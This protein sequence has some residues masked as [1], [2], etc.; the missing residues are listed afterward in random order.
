MRAEHTG[1]SRINK[2][3]TQLETGECLI[4]KYFDVFASFNDNFV[5]ALYATFLEN[6]KIINLPIKII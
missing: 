2:F 5:N 6:E 3:L 1:E 4:N